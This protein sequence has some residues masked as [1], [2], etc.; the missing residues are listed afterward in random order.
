MRNGSKG[1]S[2]L[3][4]LSEL[5]EARTIPPI[6]TIGRFSEE[7]STLHKRFQKLLRQREDLENDIQCLYSTNVSWEVK[8]TALM[9]HF[10]CAVLDTTFV[11]VARMA[12]PRRKVQARCHKS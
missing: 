4:I 7:L 10:R 12:R 5:V 1:I 9:Y 11:T 8:S 3:S 2:G 6:L